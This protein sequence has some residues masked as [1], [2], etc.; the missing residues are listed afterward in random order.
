MM[1]YEKFLPP[2]FELMRALSKLLCRHFDPHPA[3]SIEDVAAPQA[4][5]RAQPRLLFGTDY[6]L[7][8]FHMVA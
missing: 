2:F 4:L 7:S 1:L 8:V 5:P 6:P 3:P